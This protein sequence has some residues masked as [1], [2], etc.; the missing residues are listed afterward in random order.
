MGLVETNRLE[1]AAHD[2]PDPARLA[3]RAL[4][5]RPI[6]GPAAETAWS[7]VV[8]E[9]RAPLAD[10]LQGLDYLYERGER[11]NLLR[12]IATIRPLLPDAGDRQELIERLAARDRDDVEVRDVLALIAAHRPSQA[13][14]AQ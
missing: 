10:R 12:A 14:T 2:T 13:G 9:H 3:G 8:F 1:R 7:A 11:G 5:L 6:G 4:L